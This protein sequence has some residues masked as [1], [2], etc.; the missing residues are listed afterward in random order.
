MAKIIVLWGQSDCDLCPPKSGHP[1][2]FI[3]EF[4]WTFEEIPSKRNW[5]IAFTRRRQHKTFPIRYLPR[6]MS[7]FLYQKCTSEVRSDVTQHYGQ[8][9]L[10]TDCF[11]QMHRLSYCLAWVLL[12]EPLQRPHENLPC[13]GTWSYFHLKVWFFSMLQKLISSLGTVQ[14]QCEGDLV[15]FKQNWLT[16]LS[17]HQTS[18]ACWLRNKEEAGARPR[19]H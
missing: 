15:V 7:Y 10:K 8:P 5:G 14:G 1:N 4:K 19:R 17:S 3:L 12:K 9:K 11:K 6:G 18:S 13:D 2:K 16:L